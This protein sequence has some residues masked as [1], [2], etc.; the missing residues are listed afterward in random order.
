MKSIE[1]R[2][3]VALLALCSAAS[4]GAQLT[5]ANRVFDVIAACRADLIESTRVR[6]NI[7]RRMDA[8]KQKLDAE[9]RRNV[10]DLCITYA[11]GFKDGSNFF[12]EPKRL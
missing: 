3:V 10:D 2:R 6:A 11:I 1:I 9:G 7:T 5:R 4:G 8:L 12:T